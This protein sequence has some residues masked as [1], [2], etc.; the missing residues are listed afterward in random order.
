[1][2]RRPQRLTS[3]ESTSIRIPKAIR[4]DVER[5]TDLYIAKKLRQEADEIEQNLE[6][7]K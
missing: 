2:M 4:P 6:A 5:L 7:S 3:E 1:M